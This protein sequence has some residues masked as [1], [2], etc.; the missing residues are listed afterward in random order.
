M[1]SVVKRQRGKTASPHLIVCSI[2]SLRS[3]PRE[4]HHSQWGHSRGLFTSTN[5]IKTTPS[6]SVTVGLA[7]WTSENPAQYPSVEWVSQNFEFSENMWAND[8]A[9]LTHKLKS[10]FH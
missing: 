3:Q 10:A 6:G 1:M 2:Q 5:L 9:N 7:K 4:Q 8:K